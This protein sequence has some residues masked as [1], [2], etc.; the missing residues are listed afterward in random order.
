MIQ[1]FYSGNDYTHT[2]T[3]IYIYEYIVLPLIYQEKGNRKAPYE[4]KK[5]KR[6]M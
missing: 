4:T 3:Q 1:Q 6:K 2:N 5:E